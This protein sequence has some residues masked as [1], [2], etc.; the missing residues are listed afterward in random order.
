MG[1]LAGN[2]QL[3]SNVR[4]RAAI[5][6]DPLDEQLPAMNGQTGISVGQENLRV[7]GDLDISTRT[8]G[9]PFSQDPTDTNLS[10]QYS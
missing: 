3:F 5:G 7:R 6:E 9:S 1:A 2:A 8:G 4:D 10:T